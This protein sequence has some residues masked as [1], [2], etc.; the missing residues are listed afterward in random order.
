M[1]QKGCPER[2]WYMFAVVFAHEC[3]GICATVID[4]LGR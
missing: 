2:S 1:W 3:I 4:I